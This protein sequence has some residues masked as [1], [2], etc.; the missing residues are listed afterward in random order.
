MWYAVQVKSGKEHNVL[1]QCQ[2]TISGE[3]I[4]KSFIPYYEEM[5]KYQGKWEKVKSRLFPGYIFLVT[6]N[7]EALSSGLSHIFGYTRLLGTGKEI[8]PLTHEEVDF[9]EK[10]GGEDQLVQVS[11][12][13]IEND[14]VRILSGPLMGQEGLIKKIDRHKRKAYLEAQMFGRNVP[15]QVGLEIIAKR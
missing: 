9:L 8:V 2:R 10:F 7:L 14:R 1:L 6:E 13:M 5:K 11:C 15:V 4:Q 3:I 12:G